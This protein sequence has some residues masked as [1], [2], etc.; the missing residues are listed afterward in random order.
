VFLRDPTVPMPSQINEVHTLNP[1]L[2]FKIIV[3]ATPSSSGV[4]FRFPTFK[5]SH[6]HACCEASFVKNTEHAA[7]HYAVLSNLM[8]LHLS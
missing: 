1:K 6:F 2:H 5:S 7:S 4:P 3:T 8:L